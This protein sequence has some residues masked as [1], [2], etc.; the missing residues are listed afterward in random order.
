MGE[1]VTPQ[2]H[3]HHP[4]LRDEL[5]LL[6]QAAIAAE[7][8]T[9]R[10]EDTLEQAKRH[11][12]LRAA[13]ITAGIAVSLLGLVLM[14]L[15]GPGLVTLAIGLGILAQDVPFARRLLGKVRQRLPEGED[16]NVSTTFIVVSIGICVVTVSASLWWTFLR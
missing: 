8:E 3:P 11:V 16:G 5:H 15:P 10:R 13:R 2:D 14:V 4:G 9:G 12:L 6:E 1:D 7:L